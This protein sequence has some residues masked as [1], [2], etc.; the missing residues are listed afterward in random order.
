MTKDQGNQLKG[1][2]VLAVIACH[3]GYFIFGEQGFLSPFSNYGGVA[4]DLF[5]FLSAYGFA[6]S[7]DNGNGNDSHCHI[8]K[9]IFYK[10]RFFRLVPLVWI[11]L[12]FFFLLDFIILDKVYGT[13]YILR[14]FFLIFP[15]ADLFADVNSP[16]WYLTPLALYYLSFPFLFRK[17]K[18]LITALLFLGTSFILTQLPFIAPHFDVHYIAFPL[19]ILFG[20]YHASITKS[21]KESSKKTRFG[22]F[23]IFLG[24]F[25]STLFYTWAYHPLEQFISLIIMLSVVG[26]FTISAVRSCPLLFIGAYS[27]ELYLLHWPL[28]SRLDYLSEIRP[29][30][31]IWLVLWMG[32]LLGTAYLLKKAHLSLRV[33][34]G[35]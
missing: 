5:F 3:V 12:A 1:L 19:G 11:I 35:A 33:E 16:L 27:F 26:V 28:M 22:L 25:I 6:V 20:I 13:G 2:A 17:G 4:V 9:V 18:P 15:T 8:T 23:F 21:I 31:W 24:V 30:P 32:I 7:A 10:K 34:P 29:W 14:S